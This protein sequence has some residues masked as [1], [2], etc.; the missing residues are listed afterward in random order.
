MAERIVVGMS[1]GVD[2]SVAAA[3]LAE[4]RYDVVGITL[5]VW[6]WKEP[7]E[8]AARFGSCCSPSAVE[9]A[10]TVAKK[11]NIPHYLLNTE[12]EFDHA[13][14]A[15]FARE[16]EAGRTP[17]PCVVCNRDVK[18]GSLLR[19]ARAWDA[20]SVATGHYARITKDESSGRHLLWRGRD[21]HKDQSDF[22]W[23]LTQAQLSAACFPVGDLTK[24]VVREKARALGLVTADKPESQEICF[25]PDND[26]RG[27]LRE[28][29]PGAFRPGPIEDARGVTLGEHRGL[30]NYTVGQRRGLGLS[31][32][33]PLYVTAL[34]PARNTVVVGTASE[35]ETDRLWAEQVNWIAFAALDAPVNVTAKIRHS[36]HPA[37]AIVRAAP[38]DGG[39]RVE[40]CFERPQRAAAPGQ[41]VVFYQG[42]LVIG[43]GVIASR[44]PEGS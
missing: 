33:R 39:P 11:L 38:S 4:Q 13:V 29:I 16:Y 36:H 37:P 5:R 8:G 28:R 14:I 3:L 9:D 15:D 17:V 2:S 30:V 23:P 26:Y 42:D 24:E 18:F 35:V 40:V 44:G 31:T 1:G 22:L 12:K 43:G 21:Q 41:S 25:I 6:P 32:S 20:M 34:D 7:Q 10:R 27:F 19:R